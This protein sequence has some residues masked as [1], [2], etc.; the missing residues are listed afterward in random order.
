MK[1]N[2]IAITAPKK[3]R[4]I[5]STINCQTKTFDDARNALRTPISEDRSIILLMLMFIRLSVGNNIINRTNTAITV[6]IMATALL[7][8][9]TEIK[10]SK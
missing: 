8:L 4:I 7:L 6:I 10:L 2:M 3:V 1:D 5:F 9:F